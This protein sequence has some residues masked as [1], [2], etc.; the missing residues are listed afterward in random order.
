V[1]TD[2]EDFS[3]LDSLLDA[4]LDRPPAERAAF[5]A[6][7]CAGEPA[8]RARLERLVRLAEG[9]EDVLPPSGALR[10]AVWEE[11]AREFDGDAPALDA[12]KRLGRYEVRGLLGRGGMGRVYRA[13]DPALAREVAIKRLAFTGEAPE[14]RRRLEREARLLATL[15]HPNVAAIYGFEVIE[16][17][18]C[19]VLELVEGPTLAERLR[20]GPLP[21]ENAVA[22]ALQVACAL[23]EAHRKGVV[24]RDLK[25]ANV[26]L[27]PD[28]RV[29]VLDFGIAKPLPRA[30][31]ETVHEVPA[32]ATTGPG[33]ILGTAPYMSP[34][35]VRGE[36][37]D[38]RTDVWAFG[39]LLYEMLVGRPLFTGASSAEV[40]AAVLRDEVDWSALPADTPAA[41]R[42]LL[43]RCL[44]R[45]PRERLQDIGDAR[46]ELAEAGQEEGASSPLPPPRRA[47]A[48]LPWLIAA[49]AL[50]AAVAVPLARRADRAASPGTARLSL[51]LPAGLTLA[52]DFA[53]AFAVAPD[54][55]HVVVLATR[56]GTPRLYLRD[57]DTLQAAPIAGT[58]GA[59]QPFLSPDGRNVAF[60]AD[61]K[62]KRV[63]LAGGPV[64]TL[65]EI[66][67]NPRGGDW[68][69]DGTIVLSPSLR[70]GL[71]RLPARGGS[72]QPLTTLDVARGEG[73][74]RWPQVLPGNRW[75]LFTTGLETTFDDARIEAVPLAGGER[76]LLVER[77]S[78]GRY[79]GGRLFF[80]RE[81]RL[82]A[83]AFDPVAVAVRGT[84]EV[85]LEGVRYDPRSGSS[86]YA[87]SENGTLVYGAAAPTS[88]EHYLAWVDEAGRLTRIGDSARQFSE[89]RLS[90]DGR[91]V[92]AVIGTAA[93]SDVWIVDVD[94]ATLSR[95]SAGLSPH[96]PVWTRDG[97]GV[98]VGAEQDGRWRL[99][100]LDANGSGSRTTL[101]EAR[102]RVYPNTWSPD[103]RFLVF[104][105][106]RPDTAWDLR[107]LE[108][109]PDG[110]PAG[111]P[112]TLVATRF[113]ERN[114]AF[115]PDGRFLAY[116]SNEPD[117]VFEVYVAPFAD[118]AARLWGTVTGAR[119]ARWGSAG[120]LYYWRPTQ[121]RPG[122]SKVAEGLHRIDWRRD[123][124]R[125]AVARTEAVW[126]TGAHLPDPL[127]RII[128][129]LYASYDVDLSA[130]GPR[131]VVLES[132]TGEAEVPL[133][134]PVVVLNWFEELRSRVARRP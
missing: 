100:T 28:G 98:T 14:Q 83:V 18:P 1:W 76:R 42:R 106:L 52:D 86:S 67:G 55:A 34:E 117:N 7:A 121:A 65:A 59:W 107:A 60:F 119:W 120:Q 111:E 48:A 47:R 56:D 68:A 36:A 58:E 17:A 130:R 134:R 74:H 114:A 25:P 71:A 11:F 31:E 64:T 15:N 69:S 46:I 4:A 22:V 129:A 113:D 78:Y 122:E 88:R 23:E 5:L 9:G 96:R 38:T 127:E 91:R 37:V 89:P 13:F 33:A 118:P 131:F 101:L 85:V 104:Q 97:R 109:G 27:G 54:G 94:S 84:P 21:V 93:T 79:A 30:P 50:A 73:S 87:V 10:G 3:R 105:E 45:D 12:G 57:V 124:S 61:R 24:H 49:A 19:L 82:Y 80:A 41:V 103:G 39:C 95:V 115:S 35:Q 62:L 40:V 32:D 70:S 126:G 90:P 53:N 102:N 112:R 110:R 108:M 2:D 123:A 116:E 43:R 16:D 26:K 63:S 133:H 132:S 81:G 20:R 8:L 29:K 99:L 66:G 51:E 44:R 75:V 77:G 125:L 128:V 92:A 72:L 6:G